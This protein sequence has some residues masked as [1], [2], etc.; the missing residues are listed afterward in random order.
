MA[1]LGVRGTF[2]Q[3]GPSRPAAAVRLA[4]TLG[5]TSHPP[6]PSQEYSMK[7][8]CILLLCMTYAVASSA[9]QTSANMQLV[10][11]AMAKRQFTG[12]EKA[13]RKTFE[14][15]GGDDIRV[16]TFWNKET[17]ND[18]LR[19]MVINGSIGDVVVQE[20]DFRRVGRVCIARSTAILQEARSCTAYLAANP[21]W[22]LEADTAGALS[23][24]NP[25]GVLLTMIP[26]A[27]GC[28]VI[29]HIT[30]IK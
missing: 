25:G 8:I 26:V 21:V 22:K 24:I 2:S 9:Q 14:L 18:S 11:N 12:C 28:T 19:V 20:A 6:I 23:A 17:E 3:P 4:R 29:F 16:N 13:A 1:R 5:F 7:A 15:V 30:H 10:L 27:T